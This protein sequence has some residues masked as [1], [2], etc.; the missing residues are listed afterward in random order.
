MGS[1]VQ[2]HLG[3]VE[4][5]VLKWRYGFHAAMTVT[6]KDMVKILKLFGFMTP[7]RPDITL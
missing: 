3:N 2:G 6:G 5:P 1:E 4:G 7:S